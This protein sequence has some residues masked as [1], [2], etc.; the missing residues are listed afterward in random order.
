MASRPVF[1]GNFEYDARQSEIERLFDRY[2][3]IARIDMK[4]GGCSADRAQP[5]L[6]DAQPGL[7]YA[8]PGLGDAASLGP[9]LCSRP[10]PTPLCSP[11]VRRSGWTLQ[12]RGGRR[13]TEGSL[14][15]SALEGPLGWGQRVCSRAGSAHAVFL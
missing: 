5:G 15:T 3:R 1:C 8:Q 13:D 6:G 12:R 9:L 11:G 10:P 2:G 14:G 4:M 7:G